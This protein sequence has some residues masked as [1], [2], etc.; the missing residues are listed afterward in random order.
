[1]RQFPPYLDYEFV[2]NKIRDFM[3]NYLEKS[4]QKK[5]VLGLSGGLD[6]SVVAAIIAEKIGKEK[7][8]VIKLPYKTSSP[9]SEIDADRIIKKYDLESLRIE[10]TEIVDSYFKKE[11]EV[12]SL[13]IGNFCARIRMAI[14]FDLSKKFEG[15]VVG[16]GNKSEILTG[17][18]TWF[19]DSAYSLNPIGNLY[20]T[21]IFDLARYLKIPEEIINKPPSADLWVNQK[22]EDEIGLRYEE[23]DPILFLLYDKKIKKNEITEMLNIAKEK[24]ERV[25]RL[26]EKSSFKRNLPPIAE[27]E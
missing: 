7:L 18:F 17:Y 22:D 25:E 12:T 3:L 1:M 19:G 5:F 4:G 14:L 2:L 11:K 26:V 21:Q 23:L 9:I 13:R 16:T 8:F 6:S 10:I 20:K 24:V 15:L 27:I